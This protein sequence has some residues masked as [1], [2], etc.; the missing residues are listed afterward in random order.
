[1]KVS[2]RTLLKGIA[3][4]SLAGSFGVAQSVLASDSDT[5]LHVQ[6]VIVPIKS[7][8]LPAALNGVS[9]GFLSDP[10]VSSCNGEQLL[11][12]AVDFLLQ[13]ELDLILFGGDYVLVI[14]NT[15]TRLSYRS[16]FGGQCI[17]DIDG[18]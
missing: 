2:R 7:E 12:E 8:R 11:K 6:P 15:L 10:H 13:Q 9:I 3:T 1:M 4:C 18:Y 14:D 17:K 5:D 16:K